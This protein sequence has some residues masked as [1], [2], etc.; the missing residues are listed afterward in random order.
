MTSWFVLAWMEPQC[1]KAKKNGV[2][3]QIQGQHAPHC[4]GMHCIAHRTDLVVE[5]LSEF[6][7]VSAIEKLLKKL[8]SYFNKS[9]KWHLE[10]EKLSELLQ[11][12]GGNFL[13]NVKT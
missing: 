1:C 11:S 8:F 12:K 5:V 7:M 13:N 10:L 3:V 6:E 4:Q 2:T 9:P